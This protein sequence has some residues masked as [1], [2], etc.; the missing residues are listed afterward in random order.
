MAERKYI[1]FGRPSEPTNIQELPFILNSKG[2][3]LTVEEISEKLNIDTSKEF[4]AI[5]TP[6]FREKLKPNRVPLD[7]FPQLVQTKRPGKYLRP[8]YFFE[9]L[10][11]EQKLFTCFVAVQ[12]D[13]QDN[14][15]PFEVSFK[16]KEFEGKTYQDFFNFIESKFPFPHTSTSLLIGNNPVDLTETISNF[17]ETL[18]KEQCTFICTL[19]SSGRS[20]VNHRANIAA[21]I[22]ST[23][24]TYLNT[25]KVITGYWEPKTRENKIFTEAE[26][27]LIFHDFPAII[28]C[29]E[30]FLKNLE[31]RGTT[32]GAMLSDVF[33]DFSAFFKVSLLYISNYPTIINIILEKSKQKDI[34]NKLRYLE[35]KNTSEIKGNLQAFLITPVQRMPR[36]ILFLR[37]LIKFTPPSHPDSAMLL[38]ASTKL[39]EVTRQIEQAAITAENNEKL[40]TIQFGLVRDSNFELLRPSR[41]LLQSTPIQ[42]TKPKPCNGNIYLFND[43]V[44]ITRETKGGNEVILDEEPQTFGFVYRPRSRQFII[45][46]R[47]KGKSVTYTFEINDPDKHQELIN[48]IK[49][50]KISLFQ[51]EPEKVFDFNKVEDIENV[52]ALCGHDSIAIRN[53]VYTFGGENNGKFSSNMLIFEVGQN[54]KLTTISTPI[55]G[56][57][58]HTMTRVN[59]SIYIF[60]GNNENEFFTDFWE[61]TIHDNESTKL[62][63]SSLPKAISGH[64]SIYFPDTSKI[65]V[66]GGMTKQRNLLDKMFVYDI[67]TGNWE[68]HPTKGTPPTPRIHHSVTLINQSL[69]IHGG[70]TTNNY[71][72]VSSDIYVYDIFNNEWSMPKIKGD[73]VFPRAYHKALQIGHYIVFIGG[74][75]SLQILPPAILDTKQ[76]IYTVCLIGTNNLGRVSKFSMGLL[77]DQIFVYGGCNLLN[78]ILSDV[79]L[80][81]YP[82]FLSSIHKSKQPKPIATIKRSQALSSGSIEFNGKKNVLPFENNNKAKRQ[83]SNIL[84]KQDQMKQLELL[85]QQMKK[86]NA[87]DV[88]RNISPMP[89]PPIP[90]RSN[91]SGDYDKIPR[92]MV[93]R[94]SRQAS[95]LSEEDLKQI[96]EGAFD[97]EEEKKK[98]E[99]ELNKLSDEINNLSEDNEIEENNNNISEEEKERRNSISNSEETTRE[100]RNS[101]KSETSEEIQTNEQRNINNEETTRERRNSNKSETSEEVRERRNSK[102][103]EKKRRISNSNKEETNEETT[104][105]RRNSKKEERERRNSNSNK[106]EKE[107]RNSKK[108]KKERRNS[109]KESVSGEGERERRNSKK[110]EKERRNSKKEK[111]ERRNSKKEERERR[112]SNSKKE[113]TG[114]ETRERRNSK[115]EEEQMIN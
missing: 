5:S 57:V 61:Y 105:E 6:I 90:Q 23:E 31:E 4:L 30:T 9:I 41:V 21:E 2:K 26:S 81:D 13:S 112:N 94:R 8:Q 18:R 72:E 68:K 93:K 40:L 70:F 106:E 100:R 60:G 97:P 42:I 87:S 59:N 55:P 10:P 109:K 73:K 39:E 84:T 38:M 32:Y 50:M 20:R 114:E 48:K 3:G 82:N 28:N 43:L 15:P 12:T 54:V 19:E 86:Q 35:V 69:Y 96:S 64:S 44:L 91:N 34:N 24:R 14:I 66:F 75:D 85:R 101:N 74:T 17:V 47:K 104:R 25:L 98:N 79:Y 46:G 56:R 80:V 45:I 108:E 103:E 63:S 33:L 62:S 58:G 49:E 107:R 29:H 95:K 77:D 51:N 65:Y 52:P 115:K 113:E 76:M 36:Y 67:K 37:E 78:K 22:Q 1:A 16:K 11:N 111:K 110:E 7:T 27:S 89:L 102:K 88:P 53:K 99:E 83:R 71:K 92:P